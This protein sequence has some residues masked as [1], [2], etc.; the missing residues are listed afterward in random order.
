MS[1]RI[2]RSERN[3]KLLV[4]APYNS[5]WRR[6]AMKL[7]GL[8]LRQS[9]AWAFDAD[10]LPAVE[11]S[12]GKCFSVPAVEAAL[13]AYRDREARDV[14][15][16]AAPRASADVTDE[17]AP[18]AGR[19]AVK[20][21]T[22]A[23]V[24]DGKDKADDGKLARLARD[25]DA[26]RAAVNQPPGTPL[27][28]ATWNT[29]QSAAYLLLCGMAADERDAVLGA[30]AFAGWSKSGGGLKDE[31]RKLLAIVRAVDLGAHMPEGNDRDAAEFRSA[32][33]R[34]ARMMVVGRPCVGCGL[35][36]ETHGP[37]VLRDHIEAAV[38][39]NQR[40]AGFIRFHDSA[41]APTLRR[42]PVDPVPAAKQ[43][44]ECKLCG[45]TYTGD[46][47]ERDH[48]GLAPW[49]KTPT[50]ASTRKGSTAQAQSVKVDDNADAA[51]AADDG[52]F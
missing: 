21:A 22:A 50:P 39:G 18:R 17:A 34:V 36:E 5:T 12:L 24:V 25:I 20:Q 38:F 15:D 48:A 41:G 49:G 35:A 29:A 40:L 13:R 9:Q 32:V 27:G 47:C 14:A 19:L 11:R 30:F 52:D 33:Y 4:T 23:H 6:E 44:A 37:G 16:E 43:P 45:Q 26:L 10:K 2:E 28:G 42:A 46:K 7:D 31:A 8:W 1:I 51:K 3:G